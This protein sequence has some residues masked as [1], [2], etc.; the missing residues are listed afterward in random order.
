MAQEAIA[1]VA[2]LQ[3]QRCLLERRAKEMS[4]QGLK[5]LDE[6]DTTEEKERLEK[7][8]QEAVQQAVNTSVAT[9]DSPLDSDLAAALTA[10]NPSDPFWATLDFGGRTTQASQSTS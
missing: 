10:Y 7:E 9:S 6:L 4:R 1:R 2:R 5:F 3:K 8:R